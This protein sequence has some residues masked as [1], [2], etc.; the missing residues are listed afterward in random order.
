[1]LRD[2]LLRI[3]SAAFLIS[4]HD[5]MAEIKDGQWRPALGDSWDVHLVPGSPAID[6]GRA[7]G[8][9]T[10]IRGIARPQG[11]APDIGIYEGL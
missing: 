7:S 11:S 5:G 4:C 1:M 9:G 6:G 10:D 8:T 3:A 2:P